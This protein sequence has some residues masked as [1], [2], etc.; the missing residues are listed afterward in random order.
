MTNHDSLHERWE[1]PSAANAL[2]GRSSGARAV[3]ALCA[4]LTSASFAPASPEVP[5]R[6]QAEPVAIVGAT[7]HTA[8][9]PPIE[10]GVIVFDGGKITAVGPAGTAVPERAVTVEADGKHVYPGL[11][12][13]STNLGLVEINAVRATRDEKESGR[14]NPNVKTQVAINPDSELLPVA[15]AGGV[16]TALSVPQ[17][18]LLAG[19]SA[20]VHLDGW[21]WEEMTVKAPVAV[22]LYWPRMKPVRA[23][24]IDESPEEQRDER[25]RAL[26][27]LHRA[28]RDARAY[29]QASETGAEPGRHRHPV[30][31]RW[32]ALLP[33]L[34]GELPVV[35]HADGADQ[36][37]AA[38]A[39]AASQKVRII[40]DGGYDTLECLELVKQHD[41]PVIVA[42]VH[43]LPR[44]RHEPYDTPMRLPAR[45]AREKVRYCISGAARFGASALA[46]LPHHVAT[47]VAYGLPPQ[48][49]V[50]AMTLYPAEILGVADRVGSLAPAKDATLIVT[51]GDI[52]EMPTHVERAFIQGRQVDLSNRHKRLRDKYRQRPRDSQSAGGR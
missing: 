3:G 20:L 10:A 34:R 2:A 16:L 14:I 4:L 25:D 28:M 46:N 19:Q 8:Q 15:R 40:L 50:R 39:W 26:E 1:K 36:I 30:D 7:L 43:R 35:V 24:W 45:L 41:I 13:A 51:D 33:V 12:D 49:A 5:G 52:L 9:G 17:G 6:P 23:W 18:G 38:I 31:S 47:A 21:T 32:E 42:G 37:T 44:R 27:Q 11:I 48:E 29:R 22:H